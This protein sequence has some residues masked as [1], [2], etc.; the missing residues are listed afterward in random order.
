MLSAEQAKLEIRKYAASEAD[1]RAGVRV[2]TRL[3]PPLA[4]RI[5]GAIQDRRT[6]WVHIADELDALSMKKR[7]KVFSALCPPLGAALSQWWEWS[8]GAPYQ[9]GWTRR[10]FRSPDPKHSRASRWSALVLLLTHGASY[11]Q[12][13]E[14]QAS[15]L[16]HLSDWAPLGGVFA[17]AID[18]GETAIKTA[19]LDSVQS[20]HPVSGP[21]RQAYIALLASSDPN[22]WEVVER[23]LV[24][25]ER[26]EGL[27]QTILEAADVAHPEAFARILTRVVDHDLTRFAGTVRAA[28]VWLG[29]QIEVRQGRQL[30]DALRILQ[31]FLESPPTAAKLVASDRITAYLGLWALAVRDALAAI[32]VATEVIESPGEG[33]RLAAARL[34]TDLALP[35]TGNPLLRA[36]DDPSL[37][38][39]AAAVAAW[40]VWSPWEQDTPAGLEL[41]VRT[42]LA[43]RIGTL[44]KVR[45]VE[46]GILGSRPQVVGSSL[47][48]D[49][50]VSYSPAGQLDP[51]IVAAASAEGRHIAVRRY[52]HDPVAN[53]EVLFGLLTDVSSNV[54]EVAAG[55][56]AGLSAVTDT[57]VALLERALT[58]TSSDLRTNALMLLQKQEPPRL[59]ASIERLANGT[60]EQQRAATELSRLRGDFD[61]AAEEEIPDALRFTPADRT[62][63]VRPSAPPRQ[64]WERYHRGCALAWTS[65]S[66]WLDEH[67]DTE[68]QTYGGVELLTNLRWISKPAGGSLPLASVLEPWWE[69][70][71]D[72][73]TDGGLELALLSLTAGGSRDWVREVDGAIVG[74]VAD[75][76]RNERATALRNQLIRH[77]AEH[78]W[79]AS[80]TTPVLDMLDTA[81]AALRSDGLMGPPEVIAKRGRKLRRDSYGSILG[82]DDR[83]ISFRSLFRGAPG[84]LDPSALTDEQLTRLWRTLRFLDEPEG[85]FDIW[86]GPMVEASVTHGYGQI[87]DSV[88][89]VP[90]QP[91]RLKPEPRVVVAAFERGIA[92]RADLVDSLLVRPRH[93]HYRY[94]G[95][96]RGE[97]A[98][99]ALTAVRPEAWAANERT[100]AV[101]EEIR[102]AVIAQEARRGD[103]PTRLS[104]MCREL[105][106]AYGVQSLVRVV[107]ALGRRPYARGYSWTDSRD[108]G[109][110][111]LVRIHQ[112]RPEDTAEELDRLAKAARI[113]DKRLVETAVYAPQ[114]S[115]LIEQHLDWPGL[116]SAVWWVHAHTKD[117][118]WAVDA[119]IRA[120]WASEVSQRTPLD[121]TDLM[122]GGADA[123]WFRDMLATLGPER[124]LQVLAAAKYASSSGGHKRAELFAEALLG[125]LD[126]DAVRTRIRDKR[127][128]DS[129]RALGLLP[130]P[131]E[132]AETVLLARYELLRAFVASD[133]TSGSQRRASESTAV[134]VGLENLAR[135][136]GYR[137]PQRLIWAMEASAVRDLA[138]GSV[139][140]TDGD[141]VVTLSLDDAGAPRMTA[142]RAGKV[143]KSVPAKSAKVR[144][145]AALKER[146][147]HLRKQARRM[148][149]SLE[150]SCVLGDSFQSGELGTLLQHPV[151]APMLRDL[152][153]VDAEGV[154]GF[155]AEDAA[156][157][158]GPDGTR[159]PISARVRIAHPLDLLATSEW[160]D[161][162]HTVM[163]GRRPQPFKQ[164][165]RE[166][167]TLS[168]GERDEHGTSSRRYAGHQLEARRA[169]GIFTSRGWVADFEMGFSRTFHRE[170]FTAWCH[171]VDGWGSPAEVEDASIDDVTFH[172]AGS[173]HPIPLDKVPGRIFSEVMRDLDLVVSVANSGGVDPESSESSIEMRSRLIDETTALLGLHN[174]DVGGHHALVKGTLGTYSIHL[175][176]GVVHRIPGNAVCI[177]PVSAQ[178]RGRVFLPFADDDPR[179]AEVIAKVVL[180]ARDESIKDPTILEQ[181]VR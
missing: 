81:A 86:Q 46:T 43:K 136:A 143:L 39:Y 70:T 42:A 130:L 94:P 4:S 12:P 158:L 155:P 147:T 7:T 57:E 47:A 2:R 27:R 80:W 88:I 153:L 178:H 167:Y 67:A 125:K 128:Q 179:T 112:P 139:S 15:W 104:P 172:P 168:A 135:T 18:A 93:A 50:I 170:K 61:R 87:Q 116:E 176:S 144:E 22:C 105:R 90:D 166:L 24:S 19:L 75:V 175:G 33:H 44:G 21:T 169:G 156:T 89:L 124:F 132:G 161:F 36:L 108:S 79:R 14:W 53:R 68:V 131:S 127:H 1:Q 115:K 117:D 25:A 99:Q 123:T 63:A 9:H 58:R 51:E 113:S 118:G 145:I 91:D 45:E 119:G 49:V 20:R 5:A 59:A 148:R 98:I 97:E 17:A 64:V 37:P 142:E 138:T 71:Q 165:F 177:V 181:L 66:A 38:V 180:L 129:L 149:T 8:E 55:A 146:A 102:R 60:V 110:S 52:A 141:L 3:A 173:W 34:L 65:L 174:V 96:V 159:R 84:Y 41:Q 6:P 137:D 54:R 92:T 122:R 160:S 76:V 103:L 107:S 48:A 111:H 23:L 100:Q 114:W 83:D 16:L 78:A 85:T 77:V 120:Q 164:V 31:G 140:A 152:V 73:L 26:A 171:L 28:G 126:E 35:Q 72:Q 154:A 32:G 56:L 101:V 29:E 69:R 30:T 11:P 162:Q 10:A 74:P 109:L 82:H 151:L 106:S 95:G 163:T 121:S 157:L 40:P 13:L 62:P 133:R 150:A 134:E